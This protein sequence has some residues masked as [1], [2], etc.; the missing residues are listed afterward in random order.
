L[1][2]KK[3][4][5]MMLTLFRIVFISIVQIFLYTSTDIF[6]YNAKSFCK[7]ISENSSFSGENPVISPQNIIFEVKHSKTPNVVVYQANKNIKNVLNPDKPV[8][9][10]WLM[11]SKGKKVETLTSIEWRMA[12]GYKL[13]TIVSGKKY[14]ITLNAIKNKVIT[15]IQNETGKVDAFMNIN[16]NYSKLICV[17]ID[18]EYTFYL[19]SVNF[20]EFIGKDVNSNKIIA[21]KVSS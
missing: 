8:D 4:D 7:G 18:F 6:N 10:F 12:Y 1:L 14:T 17:Y 11:N 20:V 21:E 16:N 5:I 2:P 19:P 15:I 3:A 9:V 13:K